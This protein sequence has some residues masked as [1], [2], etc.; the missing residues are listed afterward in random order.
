[1]QV[2]SPPENERGGRDFRGRPFHK[3]R[4]ALVIGGVNSGSSLPQGNR[5]SFKSGYHLGRSALPQMLA[6][7]VGFRYASLLNQQ[8]PER[9]NNLRRWSS[10]PAGRIETLSW[11]R[12]K[13]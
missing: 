10:R 4:Y 1:M 6:R 5:I 11:D 7:H 12:S 2:R 8:L 9:A 13:F 3:L